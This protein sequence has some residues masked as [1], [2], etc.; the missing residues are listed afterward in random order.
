MSEVP[1]D[2]IT[3]LEDLRD[4]ALDNPDWYRSYVAEH[5][6]ISEAP[7]TFDSL[8]GKFCVVFDGHT[9]FFNEFDAAED[10]YQL[11]THRKHVASTADVS[12][13]S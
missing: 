5:P 10:W 11:N 13:D 8:L 6:P 12:D 3:L 9:M 2:R 4:E 1:E 7:I